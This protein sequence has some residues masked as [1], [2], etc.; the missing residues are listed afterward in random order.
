ME[1]RSKNTSAAAT[2]FL[3][4]ILALGM[5]LSYVE[6]LFPVVPAMPGIRIGLS[7]ALVLYLL[8]NKNG[9]AAILY[10]AARILLTFLLFGN[11]FGM[12][13]SACGALISVCVMLSVKRFGKLDPAGVSLLG[14]VSHNLGQLAVAFVIMGSAILSY[15]P[16]LMI[17]GAI[18]GYLMGWGFVTIDRFLPENMKAAPDKE[19]KRA[20]SK[21]K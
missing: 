20:Q 3:G 6:T 19:E 7:N 21:R 18:C 4:V 1:L 16:V 2:A 15:L 10:Q 8:Y 5:I 11:L 9:K 13:F 14:G 12:L 17:F